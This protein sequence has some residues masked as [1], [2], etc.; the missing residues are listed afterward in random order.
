MGMGGG[1]MKYD[2]EVSQDSMSTKCDEDLECVFLPMLSA[3]ILGRTV[4]IRKERSTG[5]LCWS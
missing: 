4:N 5:A 1:R 2:R 3:W